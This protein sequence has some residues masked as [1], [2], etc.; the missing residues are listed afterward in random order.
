MRRIVILVLAVL[1][2]FITVVGVG[3]ASSASMVGTY[4]TVSS[5]GRC[6]V[7]MTVR[8]HLEQ[9]AADLKYPIPR[10]ASGVTL[11]GSRVRTQV[12]DD[13]QLIDLSDAL[14][15]MI[16]DITVTVSYT[17]KNVTF[18]TE[19][20]LLAVQIPLLSGFSQPV[21]A[22]EF[23]VTLPGA[24]EAK[25]AFSSGYHQANIEKDLTYSVSGATISGS[26]QKELKDH[27]TLVMT[28]N[29]SEEMFPQT[30]MELPNLQ[31]VNIAMCVCAVLAAVYWL[32]TLRCAP[33][34]RMTR[35]IPPEGCTAGELSSVL[36]LEGADL[37]M[38]V[39][40]W[41]QLGYLT[42][43][44][45]R[46]DRVTLHKRMD[47]GNER[48][49]FE[50]RCYQQLFGKRNT[51]DVTGLRY[52]ELCRKIKRTAPPV[53]QFRRARS[54]STRVF[55]AFAAM[56][57]LFGGVSL[58]ISVS[59]GAVLQ[60]LL[61]GILAALGAYSS[62]LIQRWAYSLFLM[63]RRSLWIAL[64]HCGGWVLLGLIA[65]TPLVGIAVA[66]AQLFAGLMAAYGGRR[67]ESGRQA[68]QQVLGLRR[69]L[70]RAPRNLLAQ[71]LENDP[72]YFYSL[73]PYALALGV[74]MVFA[75]RFGKIRLSACPYL[76][77]GTQ[78][79]MTA[80]EWAVLMRRT[81]HIMNAGQKQ[82]L[83]E[84]VLPLLR[85]LRKP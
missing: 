6:Q 7:S 19:A 43:H 20:G 71:L 12:K 60:W 73:A 27:E 32:I 23:S 14:G 69:Y 46:K 47:M 48:G 77:V 66:G 82:K 49:E 10:Q 25:P 68:C 85:S 26:A 28:L 75:G 84:Q 79:R 53:K 13:T 65:G 35:Q 81:I 50:Q 76:T 64:L 42:I 70:R 36:T 72:D 24:P 29:V 4:A 34:R 56:I 57:G 31:A 8:L 11:N 21:D 2:A 44:L 83:S 38:M 52:S 80:T 40:S 1:M 22:L 3:A 41:A 51:V 16:G 61:V 63:D 39:F 37:T 67:T 78:S 58:G 15:V 9:A 59:A 74:D 55:R 18:R 62:F 33:F 54:G 45:D 30:G 5:D 17:L